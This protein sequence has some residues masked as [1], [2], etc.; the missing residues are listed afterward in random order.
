M[1]LNVSGILFP[2]F[3]VGLFPVDNQLTQKQAI[4]K[5]IE[6]AQNFL[7]EIMQ[8]CREHEHTMRICV[9]DPETFSPW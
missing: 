3:A 6:Q 7:E 4:V 5:M 9:G 1:L 8:M 2:C